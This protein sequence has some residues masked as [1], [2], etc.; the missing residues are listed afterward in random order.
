MDL[1]KFRA[2]VSETDYRHS[3][4]WPRETAA[5]TDRE[6]GR[7]LIDINDERNL[8]YLKSFF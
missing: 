3:I 4:S 2:T 7:L 8:K 5:E 6:F 1:A